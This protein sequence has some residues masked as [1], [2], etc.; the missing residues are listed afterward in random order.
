VDDW[1]P[2]TAY[3]HSPVTAYFSSEPA[4]IK[5]DIL[6]TRVITVPA[7]GKLSFWQTYKME[8][9]YDG[10]VI[11]ISTDGGSTFTDLGAKILSGGYNGTISNRFGNPIGGRQAWTGGVLGTWSQVNVDLGSYVGQNVIIRFRMTSDN[12][13]AGSGWYIDDIKVSTGGS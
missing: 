9:G 7:A 5:D 10:S 11:E 4:T 3:S 8:L 6:Q 1:K 12:G 2:S 13:K